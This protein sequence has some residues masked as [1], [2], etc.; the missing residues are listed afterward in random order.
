MDPK[1]LAATLR[2]HATVPPGHALRRVWRIAAVVGALG[3]VASAVLAGGDPRQFSFSWLIAFL[4]FL[5]LALG[6]TY[7]VLIHYATQAGWGVV[8]RRVAENA[9]ATL[10]LFVVLFVPLVF[11]M[12]DLFPWSV[13]GAAAADHVLHGKEPY[14]N[15]GFFLARAAICFA[16]W[17]AIALAYAVASRRQDAS[18][19]LATSAR[20]R[21]WAGPAILVLAITQTF[22]AVDWIMSLEPHWYSTIFGV[23]AFSG[24]FVGFL[25]FLA[26]VVV[27][28]RRAGLLR[29]VVTP[30]HLHDMGKLVFAFV[31]FW[32]YIGF[33]QYFLIWYGNIPEETVFFL[34]RTTGS[35]RAASALL[36]T[37]HFAVP[38]FFF[39]PRS[40]KRSP[41]ALATGSAWVLL[42][43]L[44]DVYWLVAPVLHPD[45]VHVGAADV[46]AF[47]AV[48]GMFFAVFGRLTTAA[49]LV[50]LRDPRVAESLALENA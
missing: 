9:A 2:E 37:G 21:R 50:P 26:I 35:W 20:L 16:A 48:G 10:P 49:P 8:V 34:Q 17:S 12:G 15:R 41:A 4:Y 18:G 14:L 39:L 11:R 22:A 23:Y 13:P 45:G 29:E 40:V 36:A 1:A 6:A 25:A 19:D 28:V 32:A 42:M 33:S 38:F 31:V 3:A 24:S 5:S 7:F 30:E 46:A 43:H 27:A 47:V 44:V